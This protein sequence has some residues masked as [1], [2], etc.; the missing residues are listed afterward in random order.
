FSSAVALRTVWFL[1]IFPTAYFLH[2]GYTESLFL[3]LAFG[4]IFAARTERW[5]VA[6]LL[7]GLSWMTRANGVV[8]LPTLMVEI[9]H[10]WF[11]TKRWQWRWL[12][13][14]LVPAG[15]G[16]YLTLNWYVTGDPFAFLRMR[17][18]VAAMSFAWPWVG[19][20]EAIGNFRRS[21]NQ[22]EMVGAQEIYFALAGS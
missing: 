1:L 7:G 21:P 11:A 18:T 2:I 6:G 13:I 12:W 10:Q 19:I 15:F 4:S 20:R 14:G 16:G 3:A 5:W 22:A 9:I 8:V 17:K